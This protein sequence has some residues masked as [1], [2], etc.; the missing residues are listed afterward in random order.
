MQI[1]CDRTLSGIVRSFWTQVWTLALVLVG[2]AAVP[3]LGSALPSEASL[4]SEDV[5]WWRLDTHNFTLFSSADLAVAESV[6]LDLERLR[7]VLARLG[8]ENLE[9][10][11]PVPTYLFLFADGES[12]GPYT[13][14]RSTQP[15]K[16]VAGFFLPGPIANYVAMRGDLGAE[17][18]SE[19]VYHEYL[20]YLLES[21]FADVPLWFNEGLAEF[22]STFRVTR[23]H[24][25]LGMPILDH[26]RRLEKRGLMPLDLLFA[27]D[28]DSEVYRQHSLR[29]DTFYAQSWALVHH[30]LND[31]QRRPQIM[32]Y[33]QFL[34][35][36]VPL[37]DAFDQAFGGDSFATLR[38]E[39]Q[40]ALDNHRFQATSVPLV[41]IGLLEPPE[42]LRRERMSR[43]EVLV[44]LGDLLIQL[45]GVEAHEPR[46]FFSAALDL[47][48]EHGLAWFGLA[49]LKERAL[50]WDEAEV[51]YR[52]A[53]ELTPNDFRPYFLLANNLLRPYSGLRISMG[54]V[55]AED[56]ARLREARILYRQAL[57]LNPRFGEAW[58]GLGASW[59]LEERPSQEALGALDTARR[60]L[61]GRSDVTFNLAVL[62]ARLGRLDVARTLIEREL[63]RPDVDP[64]LARGAREAVLWAEVRQAERLLTAGQV[65]KALALLEDVTSR[66]EDPQLQA[67]LR[68]HLEAVRSAE[69]NPLR[70]EYE[71]AV[72][73]IERG[74]YEQA[75]EQLVA[76]LEKL[77]PEPAGERERS[78]RRWAETQLEAVRWLRARQ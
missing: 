26:L 68:E 65:E 35:A 37:R 46:E 20:H 31:E 45:R 42:L 14:W 52:Q 61:P 40:M 3:A 25:V 6:I 36:D 66:A 56:Q 77:G 7:A 54:D 5:V 18:A 62:Q 71:Q 32:Q 50:S 75:E 47:D 15:Q 57:E 59:L 27:I 58:G 53:V 38:G 12:F 28:S 21:N 72:S 64:N 67:Q 4:P 33:L 74:Q 16:A 63:E 48:P 70:A 73:T 55:Q 8:G 34:A 29:R 43:A 60:L 22:Y 44:R 78:L 1:R 13:R 11:S 76:M 17:R 30:L 41:E 69:H 10:N 23:R 24:V 39:V 19:V 2:T 9:L 51:L 49:Q